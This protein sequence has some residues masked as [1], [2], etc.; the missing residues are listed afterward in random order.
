MTAALVV[1]GV[2]LVIVLMITVV[3]S[4]ARRNRIRHYRDETP[5]DGFRHAIPDLRP[6]RQTSLGGDGDAAEAPRPVVGADDLAAQVHRAVQDA[7]ERELVGD[8]RRLRRAKRGR[9]VWA[10][11]TAGTMGATY[12]IGHIGW[13]GGGGRDCAGDDRGG[14]GDGGGGGCGGGGCGGGCGGGGL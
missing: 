11:G 9:R 3:V 8:Y 5:E 1:V 14:G 12:G 2:S 4:R 10:A 7:P 6:R 13:G